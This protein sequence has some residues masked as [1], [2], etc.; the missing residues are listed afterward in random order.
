[1][2]NPNADISQL[3]GFLHEPYQ[4][5]RVYAAVKALGFPCTLAE[6][7]REAGLPPHTAHRCLSRLTKQGKLVR[8]QTR[9]SY[10]HVTN[11]GRTWRPGGRQR[12]VFLYSLPK[13]DAE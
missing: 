5:D 7:C 12:R 13:A 8:R 4:Q 1:M 10:A 6:I 9:M 11:Y 3:D 2:A